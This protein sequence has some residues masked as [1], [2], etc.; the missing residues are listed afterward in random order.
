MMKKILVLFLV[1]AALLSFTACAEES[2]VPDGYKL[3][4]NDEA[5]AYS[6][7]VP[8]N[9]VAMDSGST[10]TKANFSNSDHCE[11]SFMVVPEIYGDGS[12]K[13]HWDGLQA[14]YAAT[15][16]EGYAVCEEEQGVTVGVGGVN[17]Y[18]YT[19]T[20]VYSGVNYKFMQIFV[21][22]TTLTT[23]EL[24]VFTYTAVADHYDTH[25]EAVNEILS[26]ITWD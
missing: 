2:T 9:Y 11:I 22:K 3:I 12:M 15:F 18:R 26:Y 21:P 6:L 4:S 16:P 7:Y 17:G 5:C 24:Y 13:A 25:L 20:A 14:E 23:A 1:A 19:F 8:E 10:F